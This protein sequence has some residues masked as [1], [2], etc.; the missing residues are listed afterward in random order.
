MA[1]HTLVKIVRRSKRVGRGWGSRGAKSGRGQKGQKSRAGYSSKAGFEGGQTPL[2]MRL[3]KA[4]G[5]KQ[6]FASQITKPSAV[7]VTALAQFGEKTIV[8]PDRLYQAGLLPRGYQ[9]VKLV[10]TG[11]LERKLTVRVHAATPNA[12][13][14][15]EKAGGKVEIVKAYLPKPQ[16]TTKKSV[17]S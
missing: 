8:G 14:A 7:M 3:P 2:Y 15:V 10:G 6:K 12:V 4:R 9:G 16:G 13:A 1:L 11:K 5:S 17:V